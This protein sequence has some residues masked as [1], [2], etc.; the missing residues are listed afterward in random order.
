MDSHRPSSRPFPPATENEM[1]GRT[2]SSRC[3]RESE[4]GQ[5][6]EENHVT[7]TCW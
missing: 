5:E 4:G 6:G 7:L 2:F 3:V 1:D